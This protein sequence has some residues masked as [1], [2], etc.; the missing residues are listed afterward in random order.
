MSGVNSELSTLPSTNVSIPKEFYELFDKSRVI[1]KV[2]F[3]FY[4][5]D[6]MK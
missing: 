1:D 2:K 3:V 4:K 6:L 5:I